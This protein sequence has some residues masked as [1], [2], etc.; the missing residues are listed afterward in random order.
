[1]EENGISKISM[2]EYESEIVNS[3]DDVIRL[4]NLGFSCQPIGNS[5]WLMRKKY[6]GK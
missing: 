5:E 1:L 2:E 6:W 4:S 3:K